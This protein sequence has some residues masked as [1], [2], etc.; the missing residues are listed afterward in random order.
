M[1]EPLKY[2]SIPGPSPRDTAR[3]EIDAL[4]EVL[5]DSGALRMLRGLVGRFPEVMGVM[6]ERLDSDAGVNAL[7]N[8]TIAASALLAVNAARTARIVTGLREGLDSA[9]ANRSHRPPRRL[10]LL[11]KLNHPDTRRGAFAVL[12]I[13]ESIGRQLRLEPEDKSGGDGTVTV[14]A[15]AGQNAPADRKK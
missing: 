11:A 2:R 14:T 8:L 6:L 12:T 3:Q 15:T 10:Q 9:L 5:H 13:L 7:S 1:A 4:V